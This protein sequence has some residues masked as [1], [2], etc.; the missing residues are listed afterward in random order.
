ME[1]I[2]SLCK[3]L[4]E[5]NRD[6]DGMLRDGATTELAQKKLADARDYRESLEE[7]ILREARKA[8]PKTGAKPILVGII[9][10]SLN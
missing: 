5:V 8:N 9:A 4:N 6:I 10:I 7:D 2:E 1:T 3:Q